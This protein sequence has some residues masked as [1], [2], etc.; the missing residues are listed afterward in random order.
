MIHDGQE[1]TET[2]DKL[3]YSLSRKSF[4]TFVL[5]GHAIV[6]L[7]NIPSGGTSGGAAPNG[8]FAYY[9]I[10]TSFP[11]VVVEPLVPDSIRDGNVLFVLLLINGVCVAWLIAHGLYRMI[12][13]ARG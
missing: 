6:M 1:E 7:W 11:A 3:G 10:Y 12:F 5:I 8:L 9:F 4:V 2:T 13:G